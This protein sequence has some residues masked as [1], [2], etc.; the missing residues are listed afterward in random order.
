MASNVLCTLLLLSLTTLVVSQTLE[1]KLWV[2]ARD[3]KVGDFDRIIKE[4]EKNL[5]KE[6]KTKR[7]KDKDKLPTKIDVDFYDQEVYHFVDNQREHHVHAALAAWLAFACHLFEIVVV[8]F[9]GR[10]A[11]PRRFTKLVVAATTR[12][13]R[14]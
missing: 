11:T 7:G 1:H 14:I 2:A 13:W 3:G 9:L 4:M 8:S 5:E 12:S 10:R 6:R